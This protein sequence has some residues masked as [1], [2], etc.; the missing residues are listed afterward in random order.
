MLFPQGGQF[1]FR[2]GALAWSLAVAAVVA[3]A[4]GARVV[5]LGAALYAIAC[6]AT[7]VVPNPLG[8]NA[9]RLGMFVAA[10]SSCSRPGACARRSSPSPCRP[11]IWWQWSPALDGIARAGRDP[12]SVGRLPPAADRRRSVRWRSANGRIEV[13]PTQRHWETVYVATELPLARGWERQLDM[14]RN[15][16]LLR[17][18]ARPRRVPPMAARPRRAVRRPRRRADRPVR[19]G[20]R[21]SSSA[22]G[23]PFLEPVW[24]DDHWRLWRVVDA[25]PMVDGAGPPRAARTRRRSCSTSSAAEPVLVRVRY[26]SHWSLDQ[27]GCV[28]PSPDGWT[29]VHPEQPGTV[30]LRPVL[31]RSLPIIGPLDGCHS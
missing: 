4:T 12:S 13:V 25:E 5:R 20:R 11:S 28:E 16:D 8:A 24:H 10:P 17:D 26:S 1:P 30:T 29:V 15:A 22:R 19:R 7:F 14:G 31:A 18:R 3:L 27:P 23:L 2:A 6:V 9:T 21:P